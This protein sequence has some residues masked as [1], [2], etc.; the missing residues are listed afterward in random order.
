MSADDKPSKRHSV[1]QTIR[2]SLR[3][4]W[5]TAS[6]SSP[7]SSLEQAAPVQRRKDRRRLPAETA[8]PLVALLRATSSSGSP[9]KQAEEW[10]F[11]P[12]RLHA[13]TVLHKLSTAYHAQV[14]GLSSRRLSHLFQTN[15]YPQSDDPS[16]GQSAL[17][18]K[19]KIES[20]HAQSWEMAR[21]VG[22][23]ALNRMEVVDYLSR[24]RWDAAAALRQIQMLLHARDGI[25]YGLDARVRLCGAVNSHASTC[26]IDSVVA[27]L[28]GAQHAYD[29]L[30]YMRDL[31]SEAGNQL[32]AVCRLAVNHLRAG[33]LIDGG[34]AEELRS[35][36]LRCGWLG[37]AGERYTQQDAGELYMFLMEA[38]QM[39]FMPVEVRMLHGADDEAADSRMA[40]Q[41]ML[42]LALSDDDNGDNGMSPL[43]LQTLLERH[44]FDSRVENLERHL[45]T[46]SATVRTNAWSVLSV[47]PF[48]TPQSE[49]NDSN[50][51]RVAAEY[52][53]SAPLIVP[54]LL[55][56]YRVDPQGAVIRIRR[57]VVAP[58]V[59][60][61]TDIFGL[62]G[63]SS[64]QYR[65]V[66]RSA[67][68]HKGQSAS[69]GHYISICTRLHDAP[70]PKATQNPEPGGLHGVPGMVR[71]HTMPSISNDL[72]P[73]V[74]ARLRRRHSWPTTGC[75][76]PLAMEPPPYLLR[77]EPL[78]HA[79][80]E[81][82]RFD[83]LD[84]GHGRVQRFA[85]ASHGAH[86]CMDEIS[87][88]GYML[89]YELQRQGDDGCEPVAFD[90][91]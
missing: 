19:K 41:R 46:E 11:T 63:S 6:L 67:V 80:G 23:Y 86:Q 1:S 47:Y 68:C 74:A 76:P 66:L 54:M 3:A 21:Q 71:N 73:P 5:A 2:R 87:R 37:G 75:C 88:D 55:K 50:S 77:E 48:Y 15:E 28:F 16:T 34:L 57:Q 83:D 49:A 84:I 33:E 62:G 42:E 22:T 59:V 29:G 36:L 64:E 27:A 44:F 70:L 60:D 20:V 52:P 78:V 4:E 82:L 31:G 81:I 25:V 10:R 53:A 43:R 18:R 85:L 17:E 12:R 8:R 40:A 13:R 32:Q 58:V 26:Y 24:A 14:V 30:L 69:S 91:V 7:R 56:R 89:F 45:K 9:E 38:L 61:T 35:A 90:G 39:P 79:E 65:L 51:A 72:L